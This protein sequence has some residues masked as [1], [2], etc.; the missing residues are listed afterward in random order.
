MYSIN[1]TTMYECV[2]ELSE[3]GREKRRK[4][5]MIEFW[6]AREALMRAAHTR[7]INCIKEKPPLV[8]RFD[9][10]DEY[11]TGTHTH[12]PIF[13][14]KFSSLEECRILSCKATKYEI[15]R[16]DEDARTNW[17]YLR[18]YMA[19]SLAFIMRSV[20]VPHMSVNGTRVCG[21]FKSTRQ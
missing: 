17:N 21:P 11:A 20:H 15:E 8:S 3:S 12:S 4:K 10:K 6:K 13:G 1:L 9:T 14:Q 16:W 2:A 7:T 19:F 18:T 5:I